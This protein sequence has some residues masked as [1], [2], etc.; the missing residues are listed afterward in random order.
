MKAWILHWAGGE[1]KADYRFRGA[2]GIVA[3]PMANGAGLGSAGVYNFLL[4]LGVA[5]RLSENGCPRDLGSGDIL[6]VCLDG[7]I[8]DSAHRDALRTAVLGG[9]RIVASGDPL[10]WR[11]L[12][13]ELF[14]GGIGRAAN[15]YAGLGQVFPGGAPQLLAPVQ[16]NYFRFD[17]AQA[18]PAELQVAGQLA[19]IHGERQTPARAL[20]SLIPDAPASIRWRGLLY[21]NGSPFHA[22]Q[23]WLQGQEDLQ[24]WL[25]WRHRLFWLDEWVADLRKILLREDMIPVAPDGPLLP[26]LGETC[27]VLRHDLDHSRDIGYLD[28][29]ESSGIGAVHAVLRDENSKFW[30][31]TLGSHPNQECAFHYNTAHYSRIENWLRRRVG[32][33]AR[34]YAPARSAIAGTGLLKQVRWAG[35]RGVGVATLH[36]HLPFLIYPEWVDALSAVL[37][38]EPAVLGSSSLFR[39]QV[40]RWG[41]DCTDGFRGTYA[42][43]PDAQFPFWF[44]FRL[45]HAAE[46]GRILRGWES[47][48]LMEAEPALVEQ[49]LNHRVPGLAQRVIT[50]GYHPAHARRPTFAPGGSLA[51]FERVLGIV[52][53]SGARIM[54]LKAVYESLNDHCRFRSDND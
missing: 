35:R 38:E 22:L 6:F 18:P 24:P 40:L 44:P 21:L 51:D 10:A 7:P 50:L 39:G 23:A 30:V 28:L 25:Q 49:L 48:S 33:P 16:W 3:W 15:P 17:G 37:D 20:V 2:R 46:G 54:T 42:D 27:V 14:A 5:P 12:C 1:R 4:R 53:E 36:R 34:T 29:E 19:A 31:Q 11:D 9:R 8:V 47:A 13:P 32:L 41:V 43:F 52:R 26:E 45:A